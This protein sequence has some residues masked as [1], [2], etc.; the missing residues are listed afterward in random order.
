MTTENDGTDGNGDGGGKRVWPWVL[1]A[2][3][4]FVILTVVFLSL[5]TLGGYRPADTGGSPPIHVA[6][7][8]IE[9]NAT[10]VPV[11]PGVR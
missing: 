10:P 3:V 9:G 1:A 2:V 7:G 11:R 8:H 6:G 4:V 5:E